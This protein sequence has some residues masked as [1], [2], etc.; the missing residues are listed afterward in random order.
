MYEQ[1]YIMR[2]VKQF[3]RMIIKML[4]GK[5]V[6][7]PTADLIKDSIIRA[8]LEG[9]LDMVDE[10]KIN[11]AENLLYDMLGEENMI[12]LESGLIFYSYLNEQSDAFLIFN[13]YSRA[14]IK[15]G[16]K[17]IVASYNLDDLADIMFME[18]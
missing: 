10:G 15:D 14:E 1:D 2:L 13:G 5:D 7:N 9:L 3:V 17:R 16:V 4:T 8:N 18:N 12:N 11:E 6:E